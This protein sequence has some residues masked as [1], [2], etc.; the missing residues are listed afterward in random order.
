[1]HKILTISRE[2][3]KMIVYVVCIKENGFY[4]FLK[5]CKTENEARA[6]LNTYSNMYKMKE[7][8]FAIFEEEML[9]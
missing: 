5:V 9:G 8:E 3:R 7:D 4:D 6:Y 1:V 2:D